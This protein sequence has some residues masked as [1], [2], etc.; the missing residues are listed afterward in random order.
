MATIAEQLLGQASQA[1]T[2]TPDLTGSIAKGAQLAQGVEQIRNQRA[3]IEQ[4]KQELQ[5]QKANSITDTLKIAAQS[6]DPRL[7]KFLLSKVMP[8]KVKALGMD[9][10]FTPD[11]MEMIQTSDEALQKVL[12]L[13][14]DLDA[15]IRSGEIS[16]AEAYQQAQAILSNPEELAML[17]TD[18]LFAAQE[19]AKS[20][21]GKSYRA[22]QVA[23]ASLGK[24][25][26]GQQ[27]AGDVEASKDVAK[28]W[29][30]WE[31]GG[32]VAAREKAEGIFEDAI[33]RLREGKVKLGTVGKKVPWLG[34]REDVLAITDE[35]AKAL[36]DDIRGGI[37]IR[38]KTGDPNP[39]QTQIDSIMSRIIDPRLSNAE[40]IKK[41]ETE[42]NAMRA[43]TRNKISTFKRYGHPVTE[44]TAKKA[45]AKAPAAK[46]DS[47][48]S[49]FATQ[50]GMT[51]DQ[52]LQV[53]MKRGYKPAGGK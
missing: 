41:L 25:I 51:Y 20:E 13:Q 49:D 33:K 2:Q 44:P 22:E 27:A 5:M 34:G 15:K 19:F 42:L 38:E 30:T 18:Q 7:K 23:R 43:D 9:Q 39:T 50:Y 4:A 26:Q 12:G 45:P 40:N 16:G 24:Q 29:N 31:T 11:S 3:Q 21:I 1:V 8:A 53:L 32:G 14:L 6:K 52:A 35:K 46:Q 48:V 28:A 47:K 17:D 36:L 10:F 37:S